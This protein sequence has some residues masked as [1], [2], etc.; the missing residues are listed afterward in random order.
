MHLGTFKQLN[1]LYVLPIYV[2]YAIAKLENKL[3]ER[4]EFVLPAL[5]PSEQS[6]QIVL[7]HS[8]SALRVQL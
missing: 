6:S 1:V 8:S 5:G 7:V 3:Y 2:R 4:F